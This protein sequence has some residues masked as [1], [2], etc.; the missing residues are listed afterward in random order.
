MKLK[1]P[2]PTLLANSSSTARSLFSWHAS[3]R[4]RPRS[5]P[6]L[7]VVERVLV[8]EKVVVG[9]L[10]VA[11]AVLVLVAGVLSVVAEA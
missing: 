8:V 5:K 10:A 11:V 6:P 3:L 2:S 9:T 7:P 1:K 4:P